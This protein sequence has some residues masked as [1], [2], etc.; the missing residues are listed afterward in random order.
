MD[1]FSIIGKIVPAE[2]LVMHCEFEGEQI[3]VIWEAAGFDCLHSSCDAAEYPELAPH[4]YASV[5][6]DCT[7]LKLLNTMLECL[8]LSQQLLYFC[9]VVCADVSLLSIYISQKTRGKP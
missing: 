5:G 8:R 6:A 7:L 3:T 1:Y 9:R 2:K 4:G